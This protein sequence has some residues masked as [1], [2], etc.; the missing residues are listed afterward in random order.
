[1]IGRG[2]FWGG[3]KFFMLLPI[4]VRE[5]W[6]LKEGLANL[7]TGWAWGSW[8]AMAPLPPGSS[9]SVVLLLGVYLAIFW[10]FSSNFRRR[11]TRLGATAEGRPDVFSIFALVSLCVNFAVFLDAFLNKQAS[12]WPV[13]TVVEQLKLNYWQAGYYNWLYCGFRAVHLFHRVIG[14]LG[15]APGHL[16]T[17]RVL[18]VIH[19]ALIKPWL[20]LTLPEH[21]Q[22]P[23]LFFNFFGIFNVT[24]TV[25][26][27]VEEY[28]QPQL[29]SRK[30]L[31]RLALILQMYQNG[32]TVAITAAMVQMGYCDQAKSSWV[33]VYCAT[34][35]CVFGWMLVSSLL[36]ADEQIAVSLRKRKVSQPYEREKRKGKKF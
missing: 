2:H 21:H 36:S 14:T 8:R 15:L 24:L 29:I 9:A 30:T 27:S 23:S 26:F 34:S 3:E 7:A 17:Q 5:A 16:R 6:P 19:G 13:E 1:V 11:L 35:I 12:S 18:H 31:Q 33:H 4:G 20:V 22:Y 32:F 25:Y 10:L 28:L